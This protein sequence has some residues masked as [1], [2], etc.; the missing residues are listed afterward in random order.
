MRPPAS[1][2]F[3]SVAFQAFGELSSLDAS[4]AYLLKY[5][6]IACDEAVHF[7]VTYALNL[8]MEERTAL[9]EKAK[10]LKET[11]KSLVGNFCS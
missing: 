1:S 4:K 2:P 6:L 3:G 9:V 7:Y 8:A 11:L 10:D 5:P